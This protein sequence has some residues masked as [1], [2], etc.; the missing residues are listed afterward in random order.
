MPSKLLLAIF[1]SREIRGYWEYPSKRHWLAQRILPLL[2]RLLICRGFIHLLDVGYDR[3]MCM[4]DKERDGLRRAA[5]EVLGDEF[6]GII[7]E[8]A[9]RSSKHVPN[10]N[11]NEIVTVRTKTLIEPPWQWQG[12][13]Y[14]IESRAEQ[15]APTLH[16][17]DY[18]LVVG[19]ASSSRPQP[20][21]D[22]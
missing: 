12:V 8:Q 16:D 6:S 22:S 2:A 1:G 3:L 17:A 21:C 19:E 14:K 11:F 5:E 13:G 4:T 10:R 18:V 7:F 15:F 9:Q 20:A